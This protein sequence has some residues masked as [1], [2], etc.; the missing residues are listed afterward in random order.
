M[1]QPSALRFS[2]A[3]LT[4]DRP[5]EIGVGMAGV[6]TI[7]VGAL[8]NAAISEN[9]ASTAHILQAIG[10]GVLTMLVLGHAAHAFP[11]RA[12]CLRARN[13]LA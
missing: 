7:A 6:I 9:S 1:R 8:I 13:N 5:A 12:G 4:S 11:D 10:F 3:P 2:N